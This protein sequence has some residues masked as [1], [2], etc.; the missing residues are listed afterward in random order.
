MAAPAVSSH[1]CTLARRARARARVGDINY[2]VF[3]Y[4]IPVRILADYAE[5]RWNVEAR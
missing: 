5:S 4:F 1:V 3:H 2:R